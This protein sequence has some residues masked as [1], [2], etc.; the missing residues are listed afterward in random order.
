MTIGAIL[1]WSGLV[2]WTAV[3][4]LPWR[5]WLARPRL[6]PAADGDDGDLSDI[7][8]VIPARNEAAHIGRTLEALACLG[9][10]L[11]ILVV[12][13]QSSDA[14]ART[15]RL[16][17]GS[18]VTVLSGRPLPQDWTGKLWALEQARSH[19]E[20]PRVL[21]LDADIELRPGML[22]ALRARMNGDGRALVSV[23]ARLRMEGRWERLL[24]PAFVW[25]FCLL[26][27]FALAN[28]PRGRLAAAA[29]GCMLVETRW[30]EAVGGFGAL[31]DAVIDDCSLAAR[32][33]R[34]GGTTWIGLTRG[35]ISHRRYT[36][37]ADVY[38]MVARTAFAQLRY[39]HVL[40]F[41]CTALM[42]AAFPA[43]WLGLL[44]GDAA[45][46]AAGGTAVALSL[47]LYLPILRYYGVAPVW[48][49]GLPLAG[50][51]YLA[52]TLGSAWGHARGVRARWH[53]RTYS[54][55]PAERQSD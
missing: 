45:V 32:I 31:R 25:F 43:P 6:E 35:A 7:T 36:G 10:G 39:S 50:C 27:P 11:R 51:L 8:V 13:D 29:G 49:L 33:K 24:M 47:M 18:R 37:F 4:L 34:A 2:L 22:A 44:L 5:P 1:V 41:A 20:T 46:R 9:D 26:Y 17:G 54:S 15:A 14:T 48:A 42:L 19:V 28:R 53:G 12:D 40:L 38:E 16:A 55:R 30:L 3:L 21:L 23:M 52:M